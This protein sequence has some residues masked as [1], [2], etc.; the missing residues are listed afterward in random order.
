MIVASSDVRSDLGLDAMAGAAN[1]RRLASG[2][3]AGAAP[4]GLG[5]GTVRALFADADAD[6]DA[7]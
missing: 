1:T 4:S 6:A 5:D 2:S 3:M 7:E